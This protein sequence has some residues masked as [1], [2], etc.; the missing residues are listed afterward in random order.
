MLL[1]N[2]LGD[3][4]LIDAVRKRCD[5]LFN[6]VVTNA[7]FCLGPKRP[8]KREFAAER[9]LVP[10][11]IRKLRVQQFTGLCTRLGITKTNLNALRC[12]RNPR[13]PQILI[14]QHGA[15]IADQGIQPL[16]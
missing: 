3:T 2:G 12:T 9:D 13:V 4:K 16:T 15:G 11:E 7:L 6:G 8:H 10:V 14:P 1:N 5:V